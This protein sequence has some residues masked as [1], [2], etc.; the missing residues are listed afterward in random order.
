MWSKGLT[1]GTR[2]VGKLEVVTIFKQV[3]LPKY[4]TIPRIVPCRLVSKPLVPRPVVHKV[5]GK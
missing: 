1:A 5:A 2:T 4:L 3:T